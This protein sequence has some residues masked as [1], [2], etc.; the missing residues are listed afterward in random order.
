MRT[1]L[2]Y[3]SVS[4]AAPSLVL[5]QGPSH[6]KHPDKIANAMSAAPASIANGAT[7]SD[8]DGTMLRKGTN[9]WTCM[10]DNPDTPGN[11]PM[12]LDAPWL[13]WAHAW[14]NKQ[15]P[16][17]STMGF[18]Y[19]LAGSSPES[20]TDP[21]AT[22]PT[23]TNQWISESIPHIMIIVPDHRML[24]GLTTDPHNGGPWV[25]WKGTPYVHIMV[26][27]TKKPN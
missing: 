2:T 26:P 9:A 12:C 22:G 27:T 8:W 6:A 13:A 14:M 24:E 25:M 21:Y 10:P 19:M 7:V 4:L 3:L 15:K 5:A 20:N 16:E 1:L 17:Y 18:G 11:D 23:P